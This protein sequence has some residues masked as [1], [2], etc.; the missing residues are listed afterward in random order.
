MLAANLFYVQSVR[1][2][3]IG[4]F[5][6]NI[7]SE[8][9]GTVDVSWEERPP[10]PNHE[11]TTDSIIIPSTVTINDKQYRVARIQ[12]NGFD[13]IK[14]DYIDIPSSVEVIGE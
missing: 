8:E 3:K 5:E 13:E 6:F 4:H 9:E 2:Y 7:L 14:C 1:A 12:K 11:V 10:Y